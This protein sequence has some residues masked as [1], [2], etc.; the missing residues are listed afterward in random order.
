LT[1]GTGATTAGLFSGASVASVQAFIATPQKIAAI[2]FLLNI[3][4]PF[5]LK[6]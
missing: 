5:F 6:K 2:I 3:F 1:I 4:K